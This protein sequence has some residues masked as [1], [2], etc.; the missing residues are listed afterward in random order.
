MRS[1]TD[2]NQAFSEQLAFINWERLNSEKNNWAK[3]Q[4]TSNDPYYRGAAYSREIVRPGL[5]DEQRQI[6]ADERGM[7]ALGFAQQSRDINIT[8]NGVTD[9]KAAADIVMAKLKEKTSANSRYNQT[10]SQ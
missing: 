6:A 3:M 8:V 7:A 10:R 9:P 5:T 2:Q 1:V 4:S